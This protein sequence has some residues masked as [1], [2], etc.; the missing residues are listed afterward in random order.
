VARGRSAAG[1]SQREAQPREWRPAGR[2]AGGGGA[3]GVRDWGMAE[4]EKLSEK[5]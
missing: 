5:E 4:R 2:G 1:G 3:L